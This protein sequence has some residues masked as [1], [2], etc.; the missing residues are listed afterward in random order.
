MSLRTY[1]SDQR[2]F[3]EVEDE[4]EGFPHN[5]VDVFR[6]FDDRRGAARTGLGLSIAHT[7]MRAHDGDIY[8]RNVP[9]TGCIFVIE[10]PLAEARAGEM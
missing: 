8:V 10:M 6:A 1:T 4:C 5:E 2:L 3:I 9:G 7:V